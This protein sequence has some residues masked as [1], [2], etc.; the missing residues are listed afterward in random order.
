MR[1]QLRGLRELC[2]ACGERGGVPPSLGPGGGPAEL[3]AAMR[4]GLLRQAERLDAVAS[5]LQSEVAALAT[6]ALR[7]PSAPHEVLAGGGGGAAEEDAAED[8]AR[9]A[10]LCG[11]FVSPPPLRTEGEEI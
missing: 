5:A 2:A 10:A 8:G 3:L 9:I 4:S 11:A 7:E 1:E 6:S